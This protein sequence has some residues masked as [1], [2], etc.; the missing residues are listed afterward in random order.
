MLEAM[1]EKV[2][3]EKNED[4]H[5]KEFETKVKKEAN[6]VIETRFY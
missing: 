5:A 2:K 4:D 3:Q 6:V 1:K